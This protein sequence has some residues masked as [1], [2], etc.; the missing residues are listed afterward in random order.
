M[1]RPVKIR[2][3]Y[4]TFRF[5]HDGMC[6]QTEATPEESEVYVQVRKDHGVVYAADKN[7]MPST[8]PIPAEEPPMP[9]IMRH[10]SMVAEFINELIEFGM[11]HRLNKK[12]FEQVVNN[13]IGIGIERLIEETETDE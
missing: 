7:G 9:E 8:T 11:Y 12:D 4:G 1:K 2:T 6:W 3:T 10:I 13:V 5:E